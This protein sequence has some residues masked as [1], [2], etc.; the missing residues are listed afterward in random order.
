MVVLFFFKKRLECIR[1]LIKIKKPAAD[2]YGL[3]VK[4]N[5]RATVSA[6]VAIAVAVLAKT[7]S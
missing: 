5:A 6:R 2:A 7:V 4:V 1:I 3:L